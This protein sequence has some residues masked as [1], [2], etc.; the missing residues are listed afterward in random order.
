[1]PAENPNTANPNTTRAA[2]LQHRPQCLGAPTMP[3]RLHAELRADA[4]QVV[5]VALVISHL[6]P[7]ATL[8]TVMLPPAAIVLQLCRLLHHVA[9]LLQLQQV[10]LNIVVVDHVDDLELKWTT[11]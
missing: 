5:I 7:A 3:G 4:G 11:L 2:H 6:P 8:T 10:L 9:Q 1:V